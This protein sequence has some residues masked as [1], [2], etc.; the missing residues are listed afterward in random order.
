MSDKPLLTVK[1]TA[2]RLGLS[3]DY[4]YRLCERG[5]IA[6]TRIGSSVRVSEESLAAFVASR[7]AKPRTSRRGAA[8]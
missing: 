5:D 4:T 3:V 7:T 2:E 8:A 6:V 1:Q